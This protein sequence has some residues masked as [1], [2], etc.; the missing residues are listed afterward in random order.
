MKPFPDFSTAKAI[1]YH[2]GKCF[3]GNDSN[4]GG[5]AGNESCLLP[6]KGEKE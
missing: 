4:D 1:S 3:P 5:L 6:E 2:F